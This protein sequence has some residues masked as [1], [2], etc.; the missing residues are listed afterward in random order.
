MCE[1]NR[2]AAAAALMLVVAMGFGRFAFTGLYPL[3]VA[4]HQLSLDGGSYAASANYA[5]YLAGAL[6]AAVATTIG[7]RKLCAW[8]TA[9]TVVMLGL[10]G[11]AMPEWLIIAVRA[12]AGA[13]SALAMVAASHWLIHDRRHAHGAATLFAGVGLGI[14]VSAEII[15]A[16][17]AAAL[18]SRAIWLTLAAAALMVGAI[19]IA[20][21]R[22][23]DR[24]APAA[25]EPAALHRSEALSSPFGATRLVAVYG[26]AGFGY[27][28]TATYLP[29]LVRSAMGSIDPVHVWAMFGFGAAPSCFVWHVLHH[30]CGTRRSLIGNLALQAIG[31]ALPILHSPIAYVASALLVGGT[32]M[33]TVTIVMPAARR[34]AATARV[35]MLAILTAAYGVGQIVGPLIAS[36]F[37]GRTGSFD[38]SL[39]VAAAALALAAG[40]CL[41]KDDPRPSMP[42]GGTAAGTPAEPVRTASPAKLECAAPAE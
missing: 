36:N 41:G 38:A 6:L 25:A 37:Y 39:A 29:L 14:L 33:G 7:S 3:M 4:D 17:H 16:G 12:V 32:F 35:N 27:I 5:G 8:A 9:T 23:L 28:I 10:L 1:T 42:G 40:L 31:V 24:A 26:L 18:S 22:L 34:L 2:F 20:M 15:A 21:Q 30:R 13:A 19:A 11:V